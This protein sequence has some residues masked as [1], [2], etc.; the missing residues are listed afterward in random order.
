MKHDHLFPAEPALDHALLIAGAAV[1][2]A[3]TSTAQLAG[4]MARP[5]RKLATDNLSALVQVFGGA[6]AGAANALN[7][8]FHPRVAHASAGK[9]RSRLMKPGFTLAF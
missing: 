4:R 7:G 3:A 2:Q 8:S 5:E 9:A 6:D 1:S